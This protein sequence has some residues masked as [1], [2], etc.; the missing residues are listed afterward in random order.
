MPDPR[1]R[2]VADQASEH[3]RRIGDD[4]DGFG[5]DRQ[6]LRGVAVRTVRGSNDYLHSVPGRIKLRDQDVAGREGAPLVGG[7][8]GHRG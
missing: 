6:E 7:R 5:Y 3:V 8:S 4:H 2:A 1:Q